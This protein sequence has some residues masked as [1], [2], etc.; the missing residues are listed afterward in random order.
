MPIAAIRANSAM[1]TMPETTIGD[2]ASMV[3]WAATIRASGESWRGPLGCPEAALALTACIT[4]LASIMTNAP[5]HAALDPGALAQKVQEMLRP[6]R[7]LLT[8]VLLRRWRVGR[9][10]RVGHD[11]G[12]ELG[13]NAGAQ[14]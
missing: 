8:A 7:I 1:R 2:F 3:G 6:G 14:G 9:Q 12:G 11:V 13:L 10:H 4:C 5:I